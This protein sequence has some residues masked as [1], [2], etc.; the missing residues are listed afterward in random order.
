MQE[1][2]RG[3]EHLENFENSFK[4]EKSGS[5]LDK[6]DSLSPAGQR[7]IAVALNDEKRTLKIINEFAL[8]LFAIPS[9]EDLAW[10]IARE[11]V[12][13]LGFVD[14]VVYFLDRDRSVLRQVAAIGAKIG[15]GENEILNVLEIPVGKGITG[16]VAKSAE[17]LLVND[18]AKNAWYIPDIIEAGSEICVPLINNEGVIGVIDC[19][20]PDVGAFT[21]GDLETL[22]T[23]ASIASARLAL[24]GQ[25]A[26]IDESKHLRET[27]KRLSAILETC[28][29]AVAVT[30]RS[31]GRIL[32]ANP[33]FRRIFD[34]DPNDLSVAR[35]TEFWADPKDRLEFSRRY[36]RDGRVSGDEIRLKRRTGEEY[37]AFAAWE[38]IPLFGDDAI[39][40]WIY[41]VSHIKKSNEQLVKATAAAEKANQAKSEFL[42][43]MSH[44]FR[45]P[46]NAILG[47]AQLL[48]FT[49][50][51]PLNPMQQSA[52]DNIKKGGEHLLALIRQVLD[53]SKIEAGNLELETKPTNIEG[54][55]EDCAV[56]GTTM[57]DKHGIKFIDKTAGKSLPLAQIDETALKQVVLNLISNASS[58]TGPMARLRWKP[59][60]LIPTTSVSLYPIQGRELQK[61]TQVKSLNRST[62]W[63]E[64]HRTLRDQASA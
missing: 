40:S 25:Q 58:T 12:G 36:E 43:S 21:R 11:V 31:E 60:R 64:K 28:P 8:N 24:F 56:I 17:P 50:S 34:L 9:P 3:K 15:S 42:A 20:H 55:L 2:L 27:E 32:Y 22:S 52:V 30:T 16:R 57:A 37:W 29:F 26:A 7:D 38:P 10:H 33:R 23:I 5:E 61:T 53:L 39:I 46:L 44:E 18:L 35:A 63:A 45:T 14:C 19:E 13:R 59:H 51:S 48:E 62:V 49:P 4:D 1:R 41:D 47:F 54:L 6:W